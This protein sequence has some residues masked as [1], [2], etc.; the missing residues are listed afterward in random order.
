MTAN[1][2]LIALLQDDDDA[3][4]AFFVVWCVYVHYLS[5]VSSF[6]EAVKS[7]DVN[8]TAN[9]CYRDM[10]VDYQARM[11]KMANEFIGDFNDP[12]LLTL[13]DRVAEI[14][15]ILTEEEIDH[16]F[17]KELAEFNIYC[18]EFLIRYEYNWW[19]ILALFQQADVDLD[20]EA[21]DDLDAEADEDLE[22]ISGPPHK[23]VFLATARW[24]HLLRSVEI[25]F[26]HILRGEQD[27][28]TAPVLEDLPD[29]QLFRV[30][31][32]TTAA[33]ENGWNPDISRLQNRLKR[34][35]EKVSNEK[36]R[37]YLGHLE[38]DLIT[39]VEKFVDKHGCKPPFWYTDHRDSPGQQLTDISTS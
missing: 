16:Y 19:E 33:L 15:E 5:T 17:G 18:Y 39:D 20:A 9:Y 8:K 38:D 22:E 12:R 30:F 37:Q 4:Q 34:I 6:Y 32:L 2:N 14:N 35:E 25:H 3:R 31:E 11:I 29:D 24:V 13:G 1:L 27:K 7:G 10:P 26:Y 36:F 23:D 28:I 21:D